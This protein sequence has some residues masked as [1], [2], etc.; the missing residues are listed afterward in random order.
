MQDAAGWPTMADSVGP[1]VGID[2]W[3]CHF[4]KD[5]NRVVVG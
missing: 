2:R 1:C 3:S 4:L 5:E